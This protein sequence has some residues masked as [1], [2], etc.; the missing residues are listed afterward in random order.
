MASYLAFSGRGSECAGCG[1]RIRRGLVGWTD[2]L[3]SD[4]APVCRPCLDGLDKRLRAVQDV[5]GEAGRKLI[6]E[7]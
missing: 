7:A 2:E 6:E 1:R 5:F 3:E 4:L